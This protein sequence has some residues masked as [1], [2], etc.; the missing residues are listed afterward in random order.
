MAEPPPPVTDLAWDAQRAR[1]FAGGV[2]GVWAELLE[3]LPELPVAREFRPDEVGPAV[4]LPV[5]EEPLGDTEVVEHLRTLALEQSLLVGHPAFLGYI[6]GAGTV[7]GAAA[8]LLAAGLNPCVGGYLVGPAAAEIEL[9]LMRWLAGRCGLP[10]GSGGLTVTGGAMANFVALK[11]A[12][13]SALGIAVREDGVAGHGPVALY[14]SEEAHVVIRRAADMLGLGAGAVRAVA[15][16]AEQR[17]RTDALAAAIERDRAGGVRPL[18]IVATAGTTTTGSIDPLPELARLARELRLWLHVD[19]AYGGAAVLS[20]E[21]RGELGGIEHADSIAIDPHKWLYSP[22]SAGCVL[23]R[24][25]GL[26]SRSFHT[27]ATY[28]WADEAARHGV[29]FGMHGPQ[30]SRGFAVLKVWVALLAHGR[31]AFGRRIAHDAALARYLAELVT[32]HPDF[33]LMCEPRLSI[34]CFRYRPAGHDGDAA[35]LD[36]LNQRLMTELQHDG[37]VF[38]SNAVV[39][40]RFGLRACIV[41]FRTEAADVE[42]LLAVAAELGA[43]L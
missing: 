1:E 14:A 16:D 18:A 37:R 31:A 17:M 42:R 28:I 3:R 35:A 6:V 12:R 19:A 20:D 32:E 23:L 29:D 30:F 36:R 5:P 33:E 43:R 38:C 24:D 11:C 9:H 39:R 41:N 4:A 34:C 40:G 27:E 13:D 22:Q 7:P 26:L 8:E 10:D 2:A 15:A 25:F 21:L